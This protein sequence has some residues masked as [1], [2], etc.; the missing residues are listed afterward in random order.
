M[1][2][3]DKGNEPQS[4]KTHLVALAIALPAVLAV[5]ATHAQQKPAP[6]QTGSGEVV[7]TATSTNVAEPGH[8]VKIRILRW[9][10]DQEGAPLM[11]AL[12][13]APPAAPAADRGGAA[14]GA[15]AGRAAAAGGG[16]AAGRGARGRG[17]GDAPAAPL[18]P[19]AVLASAIGRAPT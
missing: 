2:G 5:A 11:A 1:A 12:S 15:E 6:G 13:P 19:T 17:R 18:S 3:Q 14:R 4:M 16:R 7:L 10:T 8:P 9:S